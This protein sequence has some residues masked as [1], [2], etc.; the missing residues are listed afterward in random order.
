MNY[1]D[2]IMKSLQH[3]LAKN[4][5]MHKIE[6]HFVMEIMYEAILDTIVD[7]LSK[8]GYTITKGSSSVG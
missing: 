1:A 4:V 5:K 3:S 8:E 7:D 2:I 6:E